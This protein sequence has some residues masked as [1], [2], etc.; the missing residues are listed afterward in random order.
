LIAADNRQERRDAD[1][2]M[3][4]VESIEPTNPREDSERLRAMTVYHTSFGD[5]DVAVSASK[6]LVEIERA[7][8]TGASLMQALRWQSTPLKLANDVAGAVA[9]LTESYHLAARLELRPE[10]WQAALYLQDVA[11][12]C[13]NLD[14]ALE[15]TAVGSQLARDLGAKGLRSLNA[16]YLEARLALMQDD[17]DR[18]RRLLQHARAGDTAILRTRAE[19]PLLAT[20]VYLR[21]RSGD[22][23]VPRK[24]LTRLR[25]LHL[26]TRGCGVRD[27]E[28]GVLVCGLAEAGE[29]KEALNVYENYVGGRRSRLRPHSVLREAKRWLPNANL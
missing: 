4:L 26:R 10:M 23:F 8:P 7:T 14:L 1:R 16:A 11:I 15:W 29:P 18:A 22:G 17:Q 21:M 3:E 20:D 2:I 9:S 28:T 24:L 27:F 13:E 6:T 25:T 5:I 12:D 19:E